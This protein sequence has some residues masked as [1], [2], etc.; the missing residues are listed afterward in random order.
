MAEALH[1]LPFA[2]LPPNVRNRAMSMVGYGTEPGSLAKFGAGVLIPQTPSQAALYAATG[3]VGKIGQTIKAGRP[4]LNAILGG[5]ARTGIL[6]GTGA[7]TSYAVGDDPLVGGIEGAG[8]GLLGELMG[9]VG[10]W[11]KRDVTRATPEGLAVLEQRFGPSYVQSVV[12]D[13]P[14]LGKFIKRYDDLIT[15]QDNTVATKIGDEIYRPIRSAI[16]TLLP[17]TKFDFP[18][19]SKGPTGALSLPPTISELLPKQTQDVLRRAGGLT[20][21][22]AL[23]VIQQLKALGSRAKDDAI[24][25]ASREFARG[26]ER[27]FISVLKGVRPGLDDMY[28][29]ALQQYRAFSG[30]RDVIQKHGS[31]L[32]PSGGEQAGLNPAAWREALVKEYDRAPREILTRLHNQVFGAGLGGATMKGE[33]GHARAYSS[34]PGIHFG[35]PLTPSGPSVVLPT[36]RAMAVWPRTMAPAAISGLESALGKEERLP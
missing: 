14:A 18:Y 16:Y 1:D 29:W 27:D 22:E 35:F 24:G 13:I 36:K 4:L 23:D 8:A 11:L 6:T 26:V 7:G 33:A 30:L 17:N 20:A 12:G 21:N 3:P 9:G 31:T 2:L 34:T 32:F 28:L 15:L 5:A 25:H 19:I 10:K